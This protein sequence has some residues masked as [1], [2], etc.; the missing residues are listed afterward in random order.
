MNL[1]GRR[2][3]GVHGVDRPARVFGSRYYFAPSI[4]DSTINGQD[5]GFEAL[6]QLIPEPFVEPLP[7]SAASHALNSMAK[8]R[9]SDN[10]D[11]NPIFINIG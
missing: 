10:A 1:C 9:K 6:R 7:A 5:A 4:G 2:D 3:E 8:L 11:E